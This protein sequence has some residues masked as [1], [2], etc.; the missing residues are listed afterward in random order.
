L[1]R[2]GR[3]ALALVWA[4]V[5]HTLFVLAVVSMAVAFQS[6]MR[7][8]LGSLEGGA[9]WAA[10][11]ALLAQFPILHSYFLSAPGRRKLARL[12]PGTVGEDLA[13]TSFTIL[14]SAQLLATVWL[15][16]PS[17]V[18]LHDARG[19]ALWIARGAFA[20]SWILLVKALYDAGLQLQTGSIGWWSVARGRRPRFGDFPRHGLFRRCRQPVYLAFALILWTAPVHTLDGLV[21]ALTWSVYCFAAPMH[22]ELRYLAIYGERFSRYR[23]EVPYILPR[24]R[25]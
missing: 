20:G 10:N 6:G 3:I 23:A 18:T 24:F 14:A 11:A 1:S 7:T 17:G 13:P 21:L 12:A 25:P 15:W 22:K 9:A 4:V 16:S 8:G 19:P 5:N 2:R